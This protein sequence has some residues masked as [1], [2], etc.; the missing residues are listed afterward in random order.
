MV[1]KGK[2]KATK[3]Q[4]AQLRRHHAAPFPRQPNLVQVR[5]SKPPRH[6][7]GQAGPGRLGI[8][9]GTLTSLVRLVILY[10]DIRDEAKRTQR[11]LKRLQPPCQCLTKDESSGVDDLD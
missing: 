8:L 3:G 4:G 1:K 11:L 9:V 6:H 10:Q 2:K 7:G 5:L